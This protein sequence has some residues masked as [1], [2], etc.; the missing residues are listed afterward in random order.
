M[1]EKSRC[2]I[3]NREFKDS[4]GLEAHNKLKHP[5]RVLKEKK[6][7]PVK[8][9]RNFG[10]FII[11]I[12]L[13]I[14]GMYWIIS[15]TANATALPPTDMK[16]HIESNPSSHILKNQ[17][18]ISIQKHMLEHADGIEKG[19]GGIIINYDCKNFEC[20]PGLIENLESFAGTYNYVYVTPF[21]NMPVKIALTK[22]GRIET[23][24]NYNKEFIIDFIEKA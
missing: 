10:I 3:C 16:G 19:R 1:E 18:P 4:N 11:I 13:I 5:E 23:L 9:V 7:F 22:L 6:P 8:K 12:G 21:K 2:E 14:F 15:G 17:M 20:E 24:D